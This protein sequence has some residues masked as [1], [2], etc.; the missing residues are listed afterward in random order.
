MKYLIS[1]F[2]F[3]FITFSYCK[4]IGIQESYGMLPN[5]TRTIKLL[6]RKLQTI[7]MIMG[8]FLFLIPDG[9]FQLY[10]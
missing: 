6:L 1:I 5:I 9:V 3:L 7:P 2:T 4:N 10:L 8:I